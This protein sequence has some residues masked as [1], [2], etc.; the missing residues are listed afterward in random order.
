MNIR[1]YI[2][3][4]CCDEIVLYIRLKVLCVFKSSNCFIVL[5][6]ILLY[7]IILMNFK[8]IMLRFKKIFFII[9]LI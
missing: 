4:S 3:Y 8:D 9:V 2:C 1:L 7:V 5:R 6:E